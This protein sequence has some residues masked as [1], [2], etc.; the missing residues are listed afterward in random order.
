MYIQG[1][2]FIYAIF[3]IIPILKSV[4]SHFFLLIKYVKRLDIRTHYLLWTGDL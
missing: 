2:V 3:A 1:Q 4:W